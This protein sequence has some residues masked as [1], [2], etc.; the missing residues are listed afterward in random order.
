MF[1][2]LREITP[3]GTAQTGRHSSCFGFE[4]H[5]RACGWR[6]IFPA[7]AIVKIQGLLPPYTETSGEN[8]GHPPA[9]SPTHQLQNPEVL[10]PREGKQQGLVSRQFIKRI[11]FSLSLLQMLSCQQGKRS[12][13][14]TGHISKQ[15]LHNTTKYWKY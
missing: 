10:L 13:T 11:T 1:H 5:L 8:S 2:S 6:K 3:F 9:F 12:P 4:E 15:H 7:S 14:G